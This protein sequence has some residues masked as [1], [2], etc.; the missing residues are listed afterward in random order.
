MKEESADFSLLHH[1]TLQSLEEK[2]QSRIKY[3][4]TGVTINGK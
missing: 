2:R 4:V 1:E 3:G